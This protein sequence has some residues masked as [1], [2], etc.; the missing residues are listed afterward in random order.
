VVSQREEVIYLLSFPAVSRK[1]AE[2]QRGRPDGEVVPALRLDP[3]KASDILIL[4][5]ITGG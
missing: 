5:Q 1:A 4:S 2:V 3:V